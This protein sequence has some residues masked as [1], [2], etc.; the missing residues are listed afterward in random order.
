[1]NGAYRTYTWEWGNHADS[2]PNNS[3]FTAMVDDADLLPEAS[4]GNASYF[5]AWWCTNRY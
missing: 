2:N 5:N 1:L 4:G 3:H